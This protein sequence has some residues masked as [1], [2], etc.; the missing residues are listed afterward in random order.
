ML[1]DIFSPNVTLNHAVH[2]WNQLVSLSN[3]FSL[4]KRLRPLT[5]YNQLLLLPFR[6]KKYI[7][8]LL[9]FFS[10]WFCEMKWYYIIIPHLN[11]LHVIE[12]VV[13]MLFIMLVSLTWNGSLN[14]L[15]VVVIHSVA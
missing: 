1:F 5:L 8:T 3:D 7:Y 12:K 4:S 13:V 14:F 2:K 6:S 10:C 11:L 15:F 9:L